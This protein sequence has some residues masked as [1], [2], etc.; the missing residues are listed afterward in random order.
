MIFERDGR[1][2]CRLP[3]NDYYEMGLRTERELILLSVIADACLSASASTKF[4][5]IPS[6]IMTD[7][8]GSGYKKYLDRL[9]DA[10]LVNRHGTYSVGKSSYTYSVS[11]K[12][13]SGRGM[14]NIRL[15]KGR[16]ANKAIEACRKQDEVSKDN[17]DNHHHV[18]RHNMLKCTINEEKARSEIVLI[19]NDL[20][21]LSQEYCLSNILYKQP[22]MSI[23][24][25]MRVFTPFCGLKSAL[26]THSECEGE[27]MV[28]IDVRASQPTLVALILNGNLGKIADCGTKR[29]FFGVNIPHIKEIG[30]EVSRKEFEEYRSVVEDGD[31][32]THILESVDQSYFH[33]DRNVVK[34][35]FM[36]DVLAKKKV[37]YD[38]PVENA[39]K[40][41]FPT[42]HQMIRKYCLLNHSNFIR[43]AQFVESEV[44]LFAVC[45]KAIEYGL[46]GFFTVHDSIYCRESQKD[47]VLRAFDYVS[48]QLGVKIKCSVGEDRD[49]L[50]EH[51]VSLEYD[52][53]EVFSG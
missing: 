21:A 11:N 13:C 51:E 5:R 8:I 29:R 10:G 16:D 42:I 6:S 53:G 30:K 44:V 38:S 39:F 17:W 34:R 50:V 19:E 1:V 37:D 18:L 20:A 14:M 26:R 25:T 31:I 12:L 48:G 52:D 32:Y 41:L 35:L 40:R 9:I 33:V 4:K 15:R 22:R 47:C 28:G 36:R 43:L 45:R 7:Y 2:F 46:D 23:G 24:T 49:V 3:E 27:C